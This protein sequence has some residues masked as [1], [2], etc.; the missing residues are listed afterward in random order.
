MREVIEHVFGDHSVRFKLFDVPDRLRL[1]KGGVEVKREFLVSCFI[2]NCYYCIGGT[3]C[4][5]LGQISPT[6]DDY[7][8]LDEELAPPPALNLDV[9]WDYGP[10]NN[11]QF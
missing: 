3:R 6:L 1:V 7:L 8:P 5:Y 10:D 9:V 11:E 4:R 2:L